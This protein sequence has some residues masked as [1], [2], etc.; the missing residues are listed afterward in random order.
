MIMGIMMTSLCINFS[1]ISTHSPSPTW[2]KGNI[3]EKSESN[4][5]KKESRKL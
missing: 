2:T 5:G 4:E 1:Y 3:M